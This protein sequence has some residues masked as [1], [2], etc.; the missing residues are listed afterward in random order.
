MKTKPILFFF[1]IMFLITSIISSYKH[2]FDF[3]SFAD[4]T[5]TI[6]GLREIRC[7]FDNGTIS[8]WDNKTLWFID[9]DVSFSFD[10]TNIIGDINFDCFIKNSYGIYE[11]LNFFVRIN[12]FEE[13]L[14]NSCF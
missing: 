1:I 7:N 10:T 2:S 3:K 4:S 8:E 5:G 14:Y 6:T 11:N 13:N 12:N 9:G